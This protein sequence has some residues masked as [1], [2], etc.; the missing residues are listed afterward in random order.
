[1][2]GVTS[3]EE[4]LLRKENRHEHTL[5]AEGKIPYQVARAPALFSAVDRSFL[6]WFSL[7]WTFAPRLLESDLPA[8]SRSFPRHGG[9]CRTAR[10]GRGDD[11]E[12]PSPLEPFG[13]T[14]TGYPWRV[15]LQQSSRPFRRLR[16][17]LASPPALSRAGLC[18]CL[19]HRVLA[20][21]GGHVAGG[22][23]PAW[24]LGPRESLRSGR[25]NR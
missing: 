16:T 13:C 22:L 5:L 24:P 15:A 14:P 18:Q 1:M 23:R 4:L 20:C 7:K 6:S 10:E 25:P 8:A 21:A 2:N 19:G 12:G 3:A 17:L 11:P 9:M